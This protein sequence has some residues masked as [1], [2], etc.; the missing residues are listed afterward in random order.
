[1]YDILHQLTDQECD[2]VAN[3]IE[4]FLASDPDVTWEDRNRLEHLFMLFDV[5]SERDLVDDMETIDNSEEK[6]LDRTGKIIKVDF[7]PKTI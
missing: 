6:V 1:M 4:S 2:L 5:M 3:S 7:T